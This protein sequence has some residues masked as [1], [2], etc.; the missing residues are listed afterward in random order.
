MSGTGFRF[1][2]LSATACSTHSPQNGET[3]RFNVEDGR[4]AGDAIV[5]FLV[6]AKLFWDDIGYT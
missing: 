1:L 3:I 6:P 5:H 4:V 2:V